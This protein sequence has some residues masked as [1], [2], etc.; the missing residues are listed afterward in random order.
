MG[1]GHLLIF[2]YSRSERFCHSNI[3]SESSLADWSHVLYGA[4]PGPGNES[5]FRWSWSH[6]QDGSYAH[7]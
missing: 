2:L 4:S 6:D 7:I 5:L 3:F 1:K